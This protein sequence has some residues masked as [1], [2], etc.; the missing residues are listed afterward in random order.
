MDSGRRISFLM[1]LGVVGLGAQPALAQSVISARSGLIH[2]VE[3]EVLLDGKPVEQ[4]V[5]RFPEVKDNQV[6]KTEEGRVE[7]LLA[8]GV[9][10]RLGEGS[11]V[12][13]VSSRLADARLELLEGSALVEAA[14]TSKDNSVALLFKEHTVTL[15]RRGLFRLD[16]GTGTLRVFEGEAQVQSPAAGLITLKEGKQLLFDGLL[17]EKFDRKTGDALYRWAGRRSEYLALANLWA[18]KSALDRGEVW[19]TSVWRFNP[20]FWMFTF[21]PYNGVYRS[22]WGW[23]FFSPRRVYSVYYQP[24]V[25]IDSGLAGGGGG[26]FDPNYGY[27]VNTGRSAGPGYTPSPGVMS[28]PAATAAPAPSARGSEASTARGAGEGGRSR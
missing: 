21:I 24:P 22:P 2:Y 7:V 4:K 15:G 6:L 5:A 28:A 13:M 3:G 18:A 20:Y 1:A 16:S 14:E 26:R 11:A 12:R 25:R 17:V 27:R 9:I 8:P 19:S 10:L 23:N